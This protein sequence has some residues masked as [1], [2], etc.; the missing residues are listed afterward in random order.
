MRGLMVWLAGFLPLVLVAE[1]V[2]LYP[3]GLELPVSPKAIASDFS[4]LTGESVRLCPYEGRYGVQIPLGAWHSVE[5][6]EP[7]TIFEAKDGAY[8]SR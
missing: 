4:L 7:S 2:F 6:Y 1:V 5:V 3:D 8:R